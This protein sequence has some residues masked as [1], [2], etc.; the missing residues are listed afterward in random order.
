MRRSDFL[1]G[2]PIA[3][4]LAACGDKTSVPDAESQANGG[5]GGTSA[6]GGSSAGAS[7]AGASG[8]SAGGDASAPVAGNGSGGKTPVELGPGGS[9]AG[10]APNAATAGCET[11][12]LSDNGAVAAPDDFSVN[13]ETNQSDAHTLLMS[14]GAMIRR[15]LQYLTSGDGEHQH[16]VVLTSDELDALLVGQ[17]V[18]VETYGPPLNTSGGHTHTVTIHPCP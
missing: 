5:A 17:S 3:M 8:D 18:V 4:W 15:Q 13:A 6:S 14:R 2:V 10:A 7:T 9:S 16:Q 1:V 12:S 11:S